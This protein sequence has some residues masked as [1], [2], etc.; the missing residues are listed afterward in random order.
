MLEGISQFS[1]SIWYLIGFR[2]DMMASV[3]QAA[4]LSGSLMC[5]ASSACQRIKTDICPVGT[6]SDTIKTKLDGF[7]SVIQIKQIP[8]E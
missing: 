1:T 4:S 3:P 7:I 8:R 2:T 6:T 5:D